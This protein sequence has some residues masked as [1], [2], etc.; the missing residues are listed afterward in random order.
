[1]DNRVKE[2][3]AQ[4]LAAEQRAQRAEKEKQRAEEEKQRAEGEKQRA[5]EEKQRAEEETRL[6]TLFEYIRAC[7][8]LV[9]AKFTVETNKK[10][11]SKG[12][13]TNPTGKRCPPRLEPWMDFLEEQRS[14]LGTL[15]SNFP[16]RAEVFRSR[17]YLRTRGELIAETRVGDEDALKLVLQDLVAEPVK[18]IIERLQDEE[19]I[20]AEF[21]IGTGITFETRAN[22][23]GEA[24]MG[25][26]ERPQ[27]P[28]GR[29]L[30]PDQICA[31]RHDDDSPAGRT[32]A[33]VIEHKP[34]H[35]LTLPHLRL[36][37]RSMNIYEDV[38]NRA[39]KPADEDEAA[40]FQ[41]HA[42][43]LV[44]A[45]VTQTF[46]YMIQAGLT[47]G[48]LITGE[49]IVFL[50]VSWTTSITLYYH[51]AEP[52]PE[53]MEHRDNFLCCTAVS[54][55]L[56]FTILAL[57][58]QA[59]RG[60]GDRQREMENLQTWAEDW[61]SILQ[62]IPLSERVAPATSPAYK[63]RTYKGIDR[64]PCLTRLRK[65]QIAD[66][67]VCNP[68][69]ARKVRSPE[70]SDD[71]GD[72]ARMPGT[73]TPTQPMTARRNIAR[74][75]RGNTS[76]T[77]SSSQ[78]SR[79]TRR[80][81]C[82][83]KCLLG[84]IAGKDLDEEC[85]NI[86]LHRGGVNDR[87]H[88]V[89]HVTWLN[90]L[91]EQFRRTLD[92]G[93]VPLGKE[94]ARGALFQVTLLSLGY[95]FVSKATTATFTRNL[96]HEAK[97]YGRVR[98]LQGICVPVFL[99]A[100]DLRELGRTYYYDAN[101]HI[102]HIVH[103]MLLSWGGSCLEEVDVL[104]R[105]KIRQEVV[106]SLRALH[107]HGV[108]HTD[109]RDTNVLWNEQ[110]GRVMVIDFEQAVLSDL[111]RPSLA[112]TVPNKRARSE[113]VAIDVAAGKRRPNDIVRRRMTDDILAVQ[114]IFY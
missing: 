60:Q 56:A 97:V 30:R 71:N 102:V 21:G 69:P 27:T 14:I 53:V 37:L 55:V 108:A 68:G 10:I 113:G 110:S 86:I 49:A 28:D 16:E 4:L 36:G 38:V 8:D 32:M 105:A 74:R 88:T 24:V 80:R 11:T 47:Y 84:L 98:S 2:L 76:N 6:T 109:V 78:S 13:M 18:L 90:L 3:E 25:S 44:A 66:G 12:S 106:R 59:R 95:T 89:D 111:P 112:P 104:N 94:G 33:Y 96:E 34:P 45:A 93:V 9:F 26:T 7:H 79:P 22:A 52:G 5:E 70:A 91:R 92:D 29:K 81:Y 15:F 35:K 103:M 17:H 82:S 42:D 23:L 46:D 107:L 101:V 31:Y 43:R 50:K 75:P 64:T 19:D 65:K 73:P 99:G 63:A 57:D 54:Q 67:A 114:T 20:K 1:M 40:S 72:E 58:S 62:A 83:Q 51:L 39:T 87:R 61:E 48:C 77:G 41:Y 100:V 85:P